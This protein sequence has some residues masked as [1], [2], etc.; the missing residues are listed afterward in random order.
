[1]RR[2][3]YLAKVKLIPV[4][5]SCNSNKSTHNLDLL[6]LIL[7]TL[8]RWSAVSSNPTTL[9]RGGSAAGGGAGGSA[10]GGG[11]SQPAGFTRQRT[12]HVSRGGRRSG[13]IVGGRP[14]VPASV[15][16]EDLISQVQRQNSAFFLYII[17]TWNWWS[18]W[19]RD[20]DGNLLF[21]LL[22]PCLGGISI[23][24]RTHGTCALLINF[25]G[26]IFL[27]IYSKRHDKV[28]HDCK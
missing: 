16:P 9:T 10:S 23:F 25:S 11:G 20:D 8:R 3:S 19:P 14:L 1:M 28:Y 5:I 18:F 21:F 2:N 6:H 12:V 26:S 27:F 7:V 24:L 15:V 4:I 22:T 13:V 17:L